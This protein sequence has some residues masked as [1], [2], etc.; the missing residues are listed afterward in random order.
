MIFIVVFFYLSINGVSVCSNEFLMMDILR[1]E[2]NFIGYVVS[3][4]G[5]IE[6]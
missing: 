2:W 6:N 5:V 4:E 1:G 3:D